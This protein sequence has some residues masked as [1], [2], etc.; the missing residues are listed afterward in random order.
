MT[1]QEFLD[2][3]SR[4]SHPHGRTRGPYATLCDHLEML[5]R[6]LQKNPYFS[7]AMKEEIDCNQPQDNDDRLLQLEQA[8]RGLVNGIPEEDINTHVTNLLDRAQ[9]V[10]NHNR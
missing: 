2:Q 10:L 9:Q 5:H 6:E 1:L 3:L 8:L 7:K 4:A